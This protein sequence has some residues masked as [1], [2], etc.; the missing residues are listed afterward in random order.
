MREEAWR[1][2]QLQQDIKEITLTD[3]HEV[4]DQTGKITRMA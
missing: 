4:M 3:H 1:K 2:D